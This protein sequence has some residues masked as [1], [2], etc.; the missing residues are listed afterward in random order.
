MMDEHKSNIYS[1]IVNA[2]L[3]RGGTTREMPWEMFTDESRG[4]AR[5]TGCKV[6]IPNGDIYYDAYHRQGTVFYPKQTLCLKCA[7]MLMNVKLHSID[8]RGAWF[9]NGR[10]QNAVI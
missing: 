9:N 2:I 5:C 3:C 6:T 8:G 1:R 10:P 7:A 4:A